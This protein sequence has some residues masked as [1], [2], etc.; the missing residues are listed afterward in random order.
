MVTQE[1]T[2]STRGR[3]NVLRLAMTGRL[4]ESGLGD[5]KVY[6]ALDLC[7][8]CRACKA[9]CPVGVDMARF[10]S[11]FLADYWARHGT[12]ISARLLGNVGGLAR[13]GSRT[14]AVTNW[15]AGN[16]AMRFVAEKLVGI[17]RRRRL[18]H[19]QRQTLRDLEPPMDDSCDAVLFVDTF[20][21]Y[22][23]PDIGVAAL[24]VLRSAGIR[25]GLVRHSCCGRPQI[26]KGLLHRARA[27]ARANADALYSHAVA[28]RKILFCEP[29]CL[30]AV[31]E[32]AP[33]LLRGEDRRKAEVVA[34]SCEL[35]EQFMN[36]V[37][38][39][40]QL[41]SG[42]PKILFHGHCHQKAMG[43]VGSTRSLLDRIPGASVIDLD[44]G[45]CGMAGSFGY[46]REHFDVSRAIGERKLFPAIRSAD[47]GAVVV[48]TGTSCRHQVK[49]FTGREPVHPAVLLSSLLLSRSG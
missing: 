16:R 24:D 42:P 27:L 12:P 37:A 31:R 13:W 33:A 39:R 46:A 41:K 29:S 25:V 7:L 8:E 40:L 10:K 5:E 2:H 35:F 3:A 34:R 17:D 9:E 21:N 15:M 11:E 49:E 32:D 1:E 30:S 47:D 48:A 14:A 26:S 43:M 18:P 23:D 19:F 38:G 4:G 20:T 28:G 36:T 22:Y 44:A 45:C 6:E